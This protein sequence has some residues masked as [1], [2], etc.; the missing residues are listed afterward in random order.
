MAS[1]EQ[2]ALDQAGPFCKYKLMQA[3][4][5]QWETQFIVTK[6]GKINKIFKPLTVHTRRT[7][8]LILIEAD[9]HCN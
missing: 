5:Q 7:K 8:L 3:T 1:W 6:I 4:S 9:L 2:E